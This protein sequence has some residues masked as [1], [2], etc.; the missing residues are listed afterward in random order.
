MVD[1]SGA[2]VLDTPSEDVKSP[3]CVSS[4][5]EKAEYWSDLAK[6]AAAAGLC[7]SESPESELEVSFL[8]PVFKSPV[9]S[10]SLGVSSAHGV[11]WF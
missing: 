8:S 3:R 5:L 9:S 11:G 10:W 2:D 6:R 7:L 4:C 1:R